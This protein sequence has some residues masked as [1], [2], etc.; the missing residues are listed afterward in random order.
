MALS[1]DGKPRRN[2]SLRRVSRK[3][4]TAGFYHASVSVSPFSPSLCEMMVSGHF[5]P[6][7]TFPPPPTPDP[8]W[9]RP[10]GRP[11]AKWTDQLRRDNNNVPHCDSVEASYWS[12]SLESDATVRA[13]YA[14]TTTTTT[15]NA[16]R[17]SAP[18]RIAVRGIT[19]RFVLRIGV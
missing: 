7:R 13:D 6:P 16:T 8:T 18:V 5:D 9:K 19:V 15:K 12:R 4:S 3:P 1:R 11:R 14:L 10:P 17:A 2:Q